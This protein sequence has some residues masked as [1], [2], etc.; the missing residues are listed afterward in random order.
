MNAGR[1]LDALIAEKV[2]GENP[3]LQYP[4]RCPECG[5]Q[6]P[7]SYMAFVHRMDNQTLGGREQ[8]SGIGCGH[9]VALTPHYSTD[10]AAAWEV[11]EK[12]YG[13]WNIG[14]M[15]TGWRAQLF[16]PQG[17]FCNKMTVEDAATAP[18]AICLAALKATEPLR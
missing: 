6:M 12:V 11:V 8:R 4:D 1:E 18:H 16:T 15:S 9:S 17:S 3:V 13:V 14:S 10:I 5:G 7:D 2:M